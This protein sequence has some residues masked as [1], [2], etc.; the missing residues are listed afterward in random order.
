MGSESRSSN[1]KHP[2]FEREQYTDSDTTAPK[3]YNEEKNIG[4]STKF[5][6]DM[7]YESNF[8]FDNMQHASNSNVSSVYAPTHCYEGLHIHRSKVTKKLPK[9]S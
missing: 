6:D 1:K 9:I 7:K 2:F 3:H 4:C 5:C 8:V